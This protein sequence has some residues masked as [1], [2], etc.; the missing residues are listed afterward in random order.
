MPFMSDDPDLNELMIKA[1]QVLRIHLMELEKVQD[2]AQDF[3]SRYITC[4]KSKMSSENLLRGP[5]GFPSGFEE[6][7]D[8]TALGRSTTPSS[9]DNSLPPPPVTLPARS[10]SSNHKTGW[11]LNVLSCL[12]L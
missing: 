10:S 12:V 6:E 5:G 1:I 3:V 8:E 9:D 11:Y 4:L 2:L 7:E